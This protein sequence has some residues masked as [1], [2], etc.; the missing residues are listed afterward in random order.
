MIDKLTNYQYIQCYSNQ[1][2]KIGCY[3]FINYPIPMLCYCSTEVKGGELS[4]TPPYVVVKWQL[5]LKII[6]QFNWTLVASFTQ[7]N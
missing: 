2:Q 3:K 7:N 6:I 4:L 1:T 5:Y